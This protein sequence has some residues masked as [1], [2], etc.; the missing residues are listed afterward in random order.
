MFC[1]YPKEPGGQHSKR[2]DEGWLGRRRQVVHTDPEI[3]PDLQAQVFGQLMKNINNYCE[4][5]ENKMYMNDV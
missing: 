4:K 1:S 2:R 5:V 3:V